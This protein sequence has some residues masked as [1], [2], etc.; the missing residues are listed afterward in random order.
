MGLFKQKLLCL[1]FFIVVVCGGYG[2][3]AQFVNPFIGTG[4]C[5]VS[6]LWGNY[7]GTYPGATA[8]WGM[9]QLTPETSIRPSESGY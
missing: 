3:N 7:G 2:Q 6:T 1:F 9:V 8:P 4:K 5:N